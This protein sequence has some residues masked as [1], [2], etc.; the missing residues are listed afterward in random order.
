MGRT[1]YTYESI[2]LRVFT[3]IQHDSEEWSST[4]KIRTIVERSVNHFKINMCIAGRKTRNHTAKKV[5]V[6]IAGI[7]SQLTVIVAYT[8]NC[9]NLSKASN[10]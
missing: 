4:Y 2:D 3:G 10:L 9:P 1:T 8:M 5:D 6:F 7:A